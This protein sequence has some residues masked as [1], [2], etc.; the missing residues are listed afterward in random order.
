MGTVRS[1][2]GTGELKSKRRAIDI[3]LLREAVD[4]GVDEMTSASFSPCQ[5]LKLAFS[6][7]I[8]CI[9][10]WNVGNDLELDC[11]YQEEQ[12][13]EQQE[14]LLLQ[15]LSLMIRINQNRFMDDLWY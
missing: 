14:E 8:M 4:L 13:E 12:Q 5:T 11:M 3:A 1:V 6:A 15:F 7:S 2:A 9:R 10:F